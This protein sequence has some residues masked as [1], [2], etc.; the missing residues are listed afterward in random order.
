ME[1]KQSAGITRFNPDPV[2]KRAQ[3]LI[4]LNRF[5]SFRNDFIPAPFE[6][7][8]GEETRT[9]RSKKRN[10][11]LNRRWRGRVTFK[12]VT[13]SGGTDHENRITCR[14]ERWCARA[15]ENKN[16]NTIRLTKELAQQR[17]TQ[18][19][20]P[21]DNNTIPHNYREMRAN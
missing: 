14:G 2:E 7:K 19:P 20:R 5:L 15:V 17:W 12:V 1:I 3:V 9:S 16:S 8:R 13:L 18:P 21:T 6:S 11:V 4:V 10:R